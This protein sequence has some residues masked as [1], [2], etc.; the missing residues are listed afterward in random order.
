MALYVT[1]VIVLVC[2]VNFIIDGEKSFLTTSGS[3]FQIMSLEIKIYLQSVIEK[4]NILCD[5]CEKE[6]WT[7]LGMTR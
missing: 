2:E 3:S 7:S 1:K 5:F 6:Y 4:L